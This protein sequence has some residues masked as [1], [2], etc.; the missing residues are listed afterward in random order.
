M[1]RENENHAWFGSCRKFVAESTVV[2][3]REIADRSNPVADG[4]AEIHVPDN[5]GLRLA[6]LD[7]ID[8]TRAAAGDPVDAELLAGLNWQGAVRVP[9]GSVAGGRLTRV[10][11]YPERF[12]VGFRFQDLDW[13]GFLA[14]LRLKFDRAPGL[15]SIRDER[16]LVL[17]TGVKDHEAVVMMKSSQPILRRGT[18]MFWKTAQ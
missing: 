18:L 4:H 13:P 1:G 15:V 2:F 17:S 16:R 6:L 12:V 8:L 10:E 14:H 5:M 3:E 11:R 9:A 7:D